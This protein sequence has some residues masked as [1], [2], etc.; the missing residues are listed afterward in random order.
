M[1]GLQENGPN[2][3]EQQLPPFQFIHDGQGNTDTRLPHAIPR[4]TITNGHDST[5]D[6]MYP[7]LTPR[8][9]VSKLETSEESRKVENSHTDTPVGPQNLPQLFQEGGRISAQPDAA[10]EI[11]M[12]REDSATGALTQEGVPGVDEGPLTA[13]KLSAIKKQPVA[14]TEKRVGKKGIASTLKKPPNKKRKLDIDSVD[15]TP[16]PQRSATPASSR[17]SKTP[18]PRNRKQSSATPMQSSPLPMS[19]EAE[20]DDEEEVDDDEE[21]FCICRKPDDHT[22]MIG[23]DGGCEDWFHGRCVKMNERDGNL[24]DKYIC[25]LRAS[26]L[27]RT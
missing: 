4:A 26:S 20:G 27:V 11:T 14:K 6:Q 2:A 7:G 19:R 23:C 5:G 8:K 16:A 22:W 1:A 9:Q 25:M 13:P 21:L 24:I 10:T 12:K 3:S 15:G 18:A 17:A